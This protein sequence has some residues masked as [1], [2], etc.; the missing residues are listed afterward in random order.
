LSEQQKQIQDAVL[1]ILDS[2]MASRLASTNVE[3][4]VRVSKLVLAQ[5]FSEIELIKYIR[6]DLYGN[7]LIGS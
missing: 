2:G 3:A 4:F 6:K 5:L 7:H 1:S